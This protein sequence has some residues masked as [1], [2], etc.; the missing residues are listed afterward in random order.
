MVKTSTMIQKNKERAS[1]ESAPRAC[2]PKEVAN[3]SEHDAEDGQ[4]DG[5]N[6]DQAHFSPVAK[7]EVPCSLLHTGKAPGERFKSMKNEGIWRARSKEEKKLY[8]TL[9]NRKL[10]LQELHKFKSTGIK[11]WIR[12]LDAFPMLSRKILR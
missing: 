2:P 6:Y 3:K 10:M 9:N 5:D 1:P 11:K 7:P 4:R 8:T 12:N